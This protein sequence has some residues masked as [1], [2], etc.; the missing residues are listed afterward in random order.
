MS[1]TL[2]RW[3]P[4]AAIIF[5]IFV[6]LFEIRNNIIGARNDAKKAKFGAKGG[7]KDSWMV[8]PDVDLR[9]MPF[10]DSITYGF[11]SAYGNGYRA[12]LYDYLTQSCTKR[13][14]TFIGRWT[15]REHGS[16]QLT[17]DRRHSTFRLHG[18]WR[19]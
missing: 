6:V 7:S 17:P 14:V 16:P 12:N 8:S 19:D 5:F 4:K 10:G 13:S 15:Q 2:P 3:A 11:G 18:K 1:S 9:I